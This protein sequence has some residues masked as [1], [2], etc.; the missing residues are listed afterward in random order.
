VYV[1]PVGTRLLIVVIAAVPIV[2]VR[3]IVVIVPVFFP[4][5]LA[6]ARPRAYA[7]SGVAF[8]VIF[9]GQNEPGVV[10]DIALPITAL[11]VVQRLV[12]RAA[13]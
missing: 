10:A 13:A 11:V 9:V 6:Q 1:L 12:V 8:P 4:V 3:I 7:A 5:Q 2:L